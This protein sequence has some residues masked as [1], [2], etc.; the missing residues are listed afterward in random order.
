[1]TTP[2]TERELMAALR[3]AG[4]KRISGPSRIYVSPGGV[5]FHLDRYHAD[6]GVVWRHYAARRELPEG[7]RASLEPWEARLREKMREGGMIDGE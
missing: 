7:A 3:A 4:R 2:W 1:M 5:R 6:T